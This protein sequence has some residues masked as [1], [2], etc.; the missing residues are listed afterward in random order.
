MKKKDKI[1]REISRVARQ[2]FGNGDGYVY[3]Y[4]SQ[5]RNEASS[6]SDWDLLV[7]T[8]DQTATASDDDDFLRYAFPFAEIGWHFGAQITPLHFTRSQW[9]AQKGTAFYHNVQSEA[10]RL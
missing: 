7:I 8:E 4:G 3:L 9:E 2:L 1:L 6:H 5:A 10:I